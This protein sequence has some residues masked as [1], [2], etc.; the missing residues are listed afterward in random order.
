[1]NIKPPPLPPS[2]R[3]SH[4]GS[5]TGFEAE[6]M[7][8]RAVSF[9]NNWRSEKPKVYD[10]Q[11]FLQQ[12]NI[13]SMVVLPGGKHLVASVADYTYTLYWIMVLVV[14]YRHGGLI[15]LAK[16][17]TETKAFNLRAKYMTVR[18]VSGI[19]IA[20]I[21]REFYGSSYAATGYVPT[22]L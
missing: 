3:Y 6:R 4:L 16:A 15:P 13:L 9:H 8:T 2:K 17:P 19:V 18:D 11:H 1:M 12:H 20:Y 7:V 10:V 21:R 14:D 22:K 5:I